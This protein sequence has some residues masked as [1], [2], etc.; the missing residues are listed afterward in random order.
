MTIILITHDLAI[1]SKIADKIGI[2]YAGQL[3]EFGSAA[4]IYKNPKHPYTQ[5]LISA[6]PK[7]HSNNKQMHFIKGDPPNMLN[8]PS[9]CRFYS[10]CPYAMEI[11]KQDPP[12]IKNETGYTRCWL[13]K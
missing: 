1:I 11:C 6:V 8:L 12:E 9:G 5:E 4:E 13:Y 3:V 2:M 10:R 7:L